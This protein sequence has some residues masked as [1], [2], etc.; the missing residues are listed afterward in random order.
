LLHANQITFLRGHSIGPEFHK[1]H[2]K[3][4]WLEY[5]L[6]TLDS[7]TH[8]VRRRI[9]KERHGRKRKEKGSTDETKKIGGMCGMASYANR[10]EKRQSA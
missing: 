6:E 8:F 7:A 1:R 9:Q 2:R 10:R 3:L 4:D 5:R